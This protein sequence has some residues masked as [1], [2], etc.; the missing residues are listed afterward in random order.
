M[1]WRSLIIRATLLTALGHSPA[2]LRRLGAQPAAP[3]PYTE[4]LPRDAGAGTEAGDVAS[5]VG[6]L[7]RT[8][9]ATETTRRRAIETATATLLE[10]PIEE[11]ERGGA[12]RGCAPDGQAS[13]TA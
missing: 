10:R 6:G 13:E 3:R 12:T 5:E 11:A 9:E 1:K 8:A 4:Q 7:G 2:A